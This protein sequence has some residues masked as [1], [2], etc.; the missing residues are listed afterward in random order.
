MNCPHCHTRSDHGSQ[1]TPFTTDVL[2]WYMSGAA[3]AAMGMRSTHQAFENM[4]TAGPSSGGTNLPELRMTDAVIRATGK[5]RCVRTHRL[6]NV[7]SHHV[8]VLKAAYSGEDWTR[9]LDERVGRGPRL[10]LHRLFTHEELQVALL[11]PR[12]LK[13]TTPT[14]QKLPEGKPVYRSGAATL[15]SLRRVLQLAADANEDDIRNKLSSLAKYVRGGRRPAWMKADTMHALAV[16]VEV[17]GVALEAEVVKAARKALGAALRIEA[18]EKQVTFVSTPPRP[19][20]VL[21][22]QMYLIELI[23]KNRKKRLIEI[24]E[25]AKKMLLAARK[26]AHV[27]DPREPRRSRVTP[28]DQVPMLKAETY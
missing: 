8:A 7:E 3:H 16:A 28:L 2:R 26:A 4:M 1:P 11:T 10:E 17:R 6:G 25:E 23:Q 12:V 19:T 24:K 14:P 18:G 15:A 13:A 21:T 20:K 27:S 22:P 9:L 5:E